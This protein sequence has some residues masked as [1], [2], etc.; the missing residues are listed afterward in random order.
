MCVIYST[1]VIDSLSLFFLFSFL[2]RRALLGLV[3]AAGQ[4]LDERQ[5]LHKL[6][7]LLLSHGVDGSLRLGGGGTPRSS[8]IAAA[9]ALKIQFII[10]CMC[11]NKLSIRIALPS[12]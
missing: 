5:P 9:C 4:A 8:H 3:Y 11:A 1:R 7:V 10:M 2:L 6:Q 12:Y